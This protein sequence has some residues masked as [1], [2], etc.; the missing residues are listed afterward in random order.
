MGLRPWGEGRGRIQIG[1]TTSA[2][3]ADFSDSDLVVGA[4]RGLAVTVLQL[5]D[6]PAGDQFRPSALRRRLRF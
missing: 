6:F 5:P 3:G 2:D 4:A 1:G